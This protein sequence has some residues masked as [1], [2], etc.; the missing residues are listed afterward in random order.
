MES[1]IR[2]QKTCPIVKEASEIV[3]ITPNLPLQCIYSP[4]CDWLNCRL[5]KEMI[6]KTDDAVTSHFI[7]VYARLLE[8]EADFLKSYN[9]QHS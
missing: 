4:R 6:C 2:L 9:E 1:E 7:L 3:D 5:K 8:I